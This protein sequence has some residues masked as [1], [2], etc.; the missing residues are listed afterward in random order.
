MLLG[1]FVQNRKG[2]VAPLLALSIVPII[3]IVGAG[4][5]YSRASAARV[6]LQAALD[7]ALLFAAKEDSST[8][9]QTATGAF[10]AI[11]VRRYPHENL[12]YSGQ[13]VH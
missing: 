12:G 3:G 4:V 1:R 5:D 7:S 13:V 11:G 8:W 9:Q 10:G 2:G 6:G